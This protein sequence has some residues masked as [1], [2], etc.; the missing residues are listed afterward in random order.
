MAEVSE[1]EIVCIGEWWWLEENQILECDN[2]ANILFLIFLWLYYY[3][4]CLEH[5][6]NMWCSFM[7]VQIVSRGCMS[8]ECVG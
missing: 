3:N 4:Q 6:E 2:M 8:W 7:N 1:A 5:S